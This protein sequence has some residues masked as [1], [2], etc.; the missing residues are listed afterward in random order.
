M[1][2]ITLKEKI[3]IVS[4]GVTFYGS[5]LVAKELDRHGDNH[6]QAIVTG[7]LTITGESARY[8]AFQNNKEEIVNILETNILAVHLNTGITEEEKVTE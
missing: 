1:I 2:L 7:Y 6:H 5:V 8:N 4:G 3:A